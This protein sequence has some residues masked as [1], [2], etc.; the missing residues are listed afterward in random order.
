MT[1][2]QNDKHHARQHL[3]A[4]I[5]HAGRLAQPGAKPAYTTDW[6]AKAAHVGDMSVLLLALRS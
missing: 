1:H 4:A 6:S 5:D 3:E 2:P